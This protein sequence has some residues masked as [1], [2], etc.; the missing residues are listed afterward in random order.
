MTQRVFDRVAGNFF[1]VSFY[2]S[3]LV[4]NSFEPSPTASAKANTIDPSKK[5]AESKLNNGRRDSQV[6]QGHSHGKHDRE[7]F[8]ANAEKTSILSQAPFCCSR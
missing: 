5:N 2:N 4:T 8:H 7:P 3:D 6:V 1:R